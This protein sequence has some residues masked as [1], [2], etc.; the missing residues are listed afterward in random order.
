MAFLDFLKQPKSEAPKEYKDL[1][2][3]IIVKHKVKYPEE[4]VRLR[5]ADDLMKLLNSFFKDEVFLQWYYD[6]SGKWLHSIKFYGYTLKRSFWLKKYKELLQDKDF[7]NK[8]DRLKDMSFERVIL[9]FIE[10]S[11]FVSFNRMGIDIEIENMILVNDLKPRNEKL[12][13][14]AMEHLKEF[15]KGKGKPMNIWSH[16]K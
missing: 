10:T 12:M 13:E 16:K 9:M 6:K 15:K 11:I 2:G 14:T 5:I 1:I 4:E 8:G 3:T 7:F